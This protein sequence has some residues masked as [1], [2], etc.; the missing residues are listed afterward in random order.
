MV[1]LRD[2]F[3]IKVAYL[4]TWNL[5]TN[6]DTGTGTGRADSLVVTWNGTDCEGVGG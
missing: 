4:P 1:L 2:T 3:L 6:R 5:G